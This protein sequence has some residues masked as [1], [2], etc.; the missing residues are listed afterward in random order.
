MLKSSFQRR[1][2]GNF[3]LINNR[4]SYMFKG[5]S[6]ALILLFVTGTELT[7]VQKLKIEKERQSFRVILC[8]VKFY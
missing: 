8:K 7:M 5:L 1:D 2:F 3:I 6:D 4:M